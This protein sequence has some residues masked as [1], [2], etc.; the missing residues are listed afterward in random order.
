MSNGQKERFL[1]DHRL[2]SDG[3][4]ESGGDCSRAGF[5]LGRLRTPY[6]SIRNGGVGIPHFNRG[7]RIMA[8]DL[9]FGY[10]LGARFSSSSIKA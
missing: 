3:V 7:K 1:P 8:E 2:F 5:C 9:K 10:K 6:L 4:G